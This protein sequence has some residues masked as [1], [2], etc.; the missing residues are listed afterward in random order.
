M[1]RPIWAGVAG[2]V[3]LLGTASGIG[4]LIATT[5]GEEEAAVQ[6]QQTSSSA[7]TTTARPGPS[8]SPAVTPSG[9]TPTGSSP[10]GIPTDW[11]TYSDPT[12]LFTIRYPANW[13]HTEN[14]VSSVDSSTADKGAYADSIHF[15]FS[16]NRYDGY[17]CGV[18][19]YDIATG[20]VA[21]EQ[22][23]TPS[24]L[25][26]VSAW[27]ILREPGDPFLND[28]YTRIEAVSAIYKGYCFNIAGYYI[29]QNPDAGIFD[30]VAAT[31]KFKF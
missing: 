20:N 8:A 12:G 4:V 6:N 10:D 25:G 17:S 11:P 30:Q 9:V 16:A 15:E 19:V 2:G 14:S 3:A 21:P 22:G 23:A 7:A 28:P 13:F 27:K 24:S 26:G 18:L 29:Q 1:I 5:G 31:L